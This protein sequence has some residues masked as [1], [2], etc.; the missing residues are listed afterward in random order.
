MNKYLAAYKV[1]FA[2]CLSRNASFKAHFI[3][4]MVMDLLFYGVT[5][6][7]TTILYDHVDQ[8]GPWKQNEFL[9]FIAFMLT[10]DHAHMALVSENFWE[11]SSQLRRGT[12]DFEL[13][14]PINPLFTVFFR[15][16]RPETLMISFVPW[17]ALIYFGYQINLEWSAWLLLPFLLIFALVLQ[18]SLEILYSMLMFV[19]VESFALNF[20]RMELQKL[21][22]WPLFIYQGLF[23]KLF[24]FVIPVLV[25]GSG[26]VTFLLDYKNFELMIWGAIVLVACWFAIGITWRRGL[27][28]YESA[29]S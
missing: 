10:L 9:F 23:R 22:R 18:V 19:T 29:S 26:P 6:F 5:F 16:I 3:L 25:I 7:S 17:S 21:S 24:L 20:L 28:R 8:I 27:R 13:L 14:K 12:L 11:F 2:T 15:Q 4:V 1:F